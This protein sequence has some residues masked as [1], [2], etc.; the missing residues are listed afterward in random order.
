MA[1]S[2]VKSEG[3][4]PI[5]RDPDLYEEEEKY[6]DDEGELQVPASADDSKVWLAKIPKWLWE[7]WADMGDDEEVEIGRL[8][9]YNKKPQDQ[10]DSKMKII[11]HD[12]PAHAEVPKKYDITMNKQTY[13]NTVVFSEKDQAG[14]KA[15]RPNRVFKREERQ[16]MSAEAYRINK[17]KKY[18]SAIP[19]MLLA[20]YHLFLSCPYVPCSHTRY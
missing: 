6:A 19:S 9:L 4:S 5:K 3:G 8:R 18:G 7:S 12:L 20:P 14:F 13:N 1:T 16:P 2:A 11:L 15:W 17:Q 10:E